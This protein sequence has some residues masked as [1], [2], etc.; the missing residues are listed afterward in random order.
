M[1][2]WKTIPEIRAMFESPL[3]SNKYIGVFTPELIFG[4]NGYMLQSINFPTF[5]YDGREQYIGGVNTVVTTLFRQGSID[6]V[7]YN[8]GEE[9][10]NIYTWGEMHYNQK[11]R[12]Y[13]YMEDI[14]AE[15]TV[16]EFDRAGNKVLEH[17]FHKC[18]LYTYGAIQLSYEEA[19][20]VETFQ[21]AIQFRN[22][23]CI[24]HHSPPRNPVN[25]SVIT[26]ILSQTQILK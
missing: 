6:C 19:Q 25:N 10:H 4:N 8:T 9:Y 23:E 1:S 16:Y 22:Y 18:S 7:F 13:G 12:Y 26:N 11:K 20:S 2:L 21:A 5:S 14:Y 17:K 15:F 3:F 24:L